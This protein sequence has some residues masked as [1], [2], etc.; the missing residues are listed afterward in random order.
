MFQ[1]EKIIES[2]NEKVKAKGIEINAYRDK[3]NI[4][5]VNEMS[6]AEQGGKG[7]AE[8]QSKLWLRFMR[9]ASRGT[10]LSNGV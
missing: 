1:L 7:D 10:S 2:F 3:Y 9:T 6:A 5:F 4:R 8:S